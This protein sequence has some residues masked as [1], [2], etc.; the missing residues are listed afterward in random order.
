MNPTS[1]NV[2]KTISIAGNRKLLG[3]MTGTIQG[4]NTDQTDKT[5]RAHFLSLSVPGLGHHILSPTTALKRGITTTLET[6]NPHLRKGDIMVQLE[7]QLGGRGL[8]S[9][10][11][12]LE[13]RNS[14]IKAPTTPAVA[15]TAKPQRNGVS[16][17]NG[18]TLA[19]VT[20]C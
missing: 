12:D 17:R 16:E 13:A 14:A 18:Q 20:K 1:P 11:V 4:T 3:T 8:C 2:P 15:L 19:V 10:K 9:F 6:G 5:H 7:H